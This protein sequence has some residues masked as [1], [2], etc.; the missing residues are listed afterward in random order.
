MTIACYVA[1]INSL[2]PRPFE[3]RS[4]LHPDYDLMQCLKRSCNRCQGS[5]QR[6]LLI[7]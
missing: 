2:N 3:T 5:L 7:D 6:F 1:E 4:G